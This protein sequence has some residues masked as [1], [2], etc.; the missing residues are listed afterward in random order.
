M[1]VAAVRGIAELG[2][3]MQA[4]VLRIMSLGTVLA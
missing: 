3:A 2:R 4:L 1:L